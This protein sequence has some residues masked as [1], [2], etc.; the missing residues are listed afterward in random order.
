[1]EE[2]LEKTSKITKVYNLTG[3]QTGELTGESSE[4]S[5]DNCN[6]SRL[7]VQWPIGGYTW[8]CT[9]RLVYQTQDYLY[10]RWGSTMQIEANSWLVQPGSL[11]M[12]AVSRKADESTRKGK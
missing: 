9:S 10:E 1:M 2:Q 7:K 11:G 4:C 8:E 6:G 5:T 12:C 3:M